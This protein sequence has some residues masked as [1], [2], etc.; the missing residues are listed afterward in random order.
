M[1]L[2]IVSLSLIFAALALVY[3]AAK[4]KPVRNSLL[5]SVGLHAVLFIRFFSGAESFSTPTHYDA[6]D[7]TFIPTF[8]EA[9]PQRSPQSTQVASVTDGVK[10]YGGDVSSISEK[11]VEEKVIEQKPDNQPS[12][13]KDDKLPPLED[14]KWFDFDEHPQGASYRRK[15]H[16]LVNEHQ[17]VPKEIME[18]GWDARIRVWFNL[19][20]DGKLNKVFVDRYFKSEYGLINKA[21]MDSVRTAARFFP[22]LPKGVRNADVWFE[23]TLDY[24]RFRK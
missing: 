21:S 16:R 17:V 22:P 6:I 24:T 20:P 7:F 1:L 3:L 12:K 15:L 5:I 2:M 8:Q 23:V 18:K 14:I 4:E 19:S 9:V 10:L 11:P 13:T